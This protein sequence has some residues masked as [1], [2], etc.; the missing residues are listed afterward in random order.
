N[1]SHNPIFG[2]TK[3]CRNPE[4]SPAGSSSGSASLIGAGGSLF[5]TGSDFGGSLRAPAHFCGISSIK[6]TI[7]R[8]SDKGLQTCVP[9]I[10]L[11]SVPGILA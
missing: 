10:G 1:G 6:P 2:N 5:G 7:G 4:L 11:P 9:S 8:L 3:N